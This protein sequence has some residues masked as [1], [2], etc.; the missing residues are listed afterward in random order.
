M[1]PLILGVLA[2]VIAP[3]NRE[4]ADQLQDVR[5]VL[6]PT[7]TSSLFPT[8]QEPREEV[9]QVLTE[10][11]GGSLP[12]DPLDDQPELTDTFATVAE[13]LEAGRSDRL[14]VFSADWCGPCQAYKQALSPWEPSESF[15]AKI[16]IVDID[17]FPHLSRLFGVQA[18]PATYD[19]TNLFVGAQSQAWLRSRIP[20]PPTVETGKVAAPTPSIQSAG[21]YYVPRYVR[22]MTKAEQRRATRRSRR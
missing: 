1:L 14:V 19:G 7:D 10:T 5:E 4:F 12:P 13:F 15:D 21:S 16:Q 6:Q 20:S 22:P 8:T 11:A 3:H 9:I 17:R 2:F 18:I